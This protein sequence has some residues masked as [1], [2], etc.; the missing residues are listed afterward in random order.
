M[1]EGA[2]CSFQVKHCSHDSIFRAKYTR[3]QKAQKI[4]VLRCFP[5]CCPNHVYYRYCGAPISIVTTLP[6][7]KTL[8]NYV[9]LLKIAPAYDQDWA[10]GDIIQPVTLE[11]MSVMIQSVGST[12]HVGRQEYMGNN[13]MIS[14]FNQELIDGW[15]YG[16]KSGRSQAVRECLHH[17]KAFVFEII[18]EPTVR[19]KIIARVFSPGFTFVSYRSL[20][21]S[22]VT[23]SLVPESPSP[24]NLTENQTIQNYSGGNISPQPISSQTQ[25]MANRLGFL[26]VSLKIFAL[27]TNGTK[28]Q[29]HLIQNLFGTDIAKVMCVAPL[30]TAFSSHVAESDLKVDTPLQLVVDWFVH[31]FTPNYVE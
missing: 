23:N 9:S 4:K 25:L 28:W 7:L 29:S 24:S 19:W 21:Y 16:W 2:S 14:C 5:H 30:S 8:E 1:S 31:L 11:Y 3:Y 6:S 12:W 10:I 13:S 20:H 27:A 18:N 26:M 22:K 17:V 15:V